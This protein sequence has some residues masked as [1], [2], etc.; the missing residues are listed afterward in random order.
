MTTLEETSDKNV[1]MVL[2]CLQQIAS[3]H[4]DIHINADTY[5]DS[6]CF[7]IN[8]F[9][10]V[11]EKVTDKIIT[12]EEAVEYFATQFPELYG[13]GK[14]ISSAYDA[15]LNE[16]CNLTNRTQ[17]ERNNCKERLS[18][19]AAIKPKQIE[20]LA[21]DRAA[22]CYK[23]AGKAGGVAVKSG[24]IG[25]AGGGTILLSAAAAEVAAASAVAA[26]AVEVAATA[27]TIIVGGAAVATGAALVAGGGALALGLG[28][29]AAHHWSKRSEEEIQQEKNQW[30]ATE[31]HFSQ[32]T[33]QNE[34]IKE[35]I[36]REKSL[37][38]KV[39]LRLESIAKQML[40]AK[41]K[42]SEIVKCILKRQSNEV[43]NLMDECEKY[44]KLRM[45]TKN[46]I[47]P[48]NAVC[49][50]HRHNSRGGDC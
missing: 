23:V 25:A 16:L 36:D 3:D 20:T 24:C 35:V 30:K 45:Q 41:D 19:L 4:K 10:H 33:E 11:M 38:L 32:L 48:E 26:C 14:Q 46:T 28:V 31:A 9:N 50:T 27:G 37:L 29:K 18:R 15:S 49:T 5:V 44:K 43:R 7:A 34:K 47:Y 2:Q 22:G 1:I 12:P 21:N 6:I 17:D 8:D 39:N 13:K 42:T 40:L